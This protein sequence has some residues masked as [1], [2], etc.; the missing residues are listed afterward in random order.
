MQH[1]IVPVSLVTG[2][3]CVLIGYRRRRYR[4]SGS[5]DPLRKPLLATL[6]VWGAFTVVL[7]VLQA[8]QLAHL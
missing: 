1:F 4:R 2:L 6:L 5:I 7:F 3:L 8:V